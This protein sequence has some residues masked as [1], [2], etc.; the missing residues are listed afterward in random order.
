MLRVGLYIAFEVGAFTGNEKKIPI[1][2]RAVKQRRLVG[3]LTAP[4]MYFLGRFILRRGGHGSGCR[5]DRPFS[6]LLRVFVPLVFIAE[7]TSL[8]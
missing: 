3:L 4:I 2:D 1:R 7:S 8:G 6:R 5:D